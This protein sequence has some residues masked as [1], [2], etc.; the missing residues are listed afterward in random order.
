VEIGKAG[1]LISKENELAAAAG[2]ISRLPVYGQGGSGASNGEESQGAITSM[3]PNPRLQQQQNQE[4]LRLRQLRMQMQLQMQQDCV[5]VRQQGTHNQS[6]NMQRHII[7]SLQQQGPYSGW[8]AT[9]TVDQRAV[10]VRLLMDWLRLIKPVIELGRVVQVSLSFEQKA[11][12]QSQSQDA[13]ITMCLEKLDQI[14]EVLR[15][16]QNSANTQNAPKPDQGRVTDAANGPEP[17]FPSTTSAPDAN[18]SPPQS[19]STA[20]TATARPYEIGQATTPNVAIQQGNMQE[21]TNFMQG[22]QP[23]SLSPW[24]PTKEDNEAINKLAVQMAENTPQ[25]D[26]AKI[27]ANLD[28]LTTQQRELLYQKGVDPVRYFFRTQAAKEYR[29]QKMNAMAASSNTDEGNGNPSNGAQGQEQRQN[30]VGVQGNWP[31]SIN[32]QAG[33]PYLGNLDHFQGQQADGLRWQEAGQLV[34]PAST[35]TQG[36]NPDQFRLQQQMLQR[37][38]LFGGQNLVN[39][40]FLAQQQHIQQAQQAQQDKVQ[41]A[42]Q[43]QARSQ[44]EARSRLQFAQNEHGLQGMPIL[45]C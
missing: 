37:Q 42:P 31:L 29:R 28:L 4:M 35:N 34:V 5:A 26:M 43:F 25:E 27:R 22:Q 23:K 6:N 19:T 45:Q 13:Y 11:F 32:E 38:Q 41:D 20:A 33:T 8:Q 36:M 21:N 17:E 1:T 39:P 10:Q 24:K 2:S 40:N 16:Q 30:I 9:I 44:A 7:S 3:A 14:Q 15:V 18:I 12:D